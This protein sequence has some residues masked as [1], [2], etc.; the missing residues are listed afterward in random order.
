MLGKVVSLEKARVNVRVD[1]QMKVGQLFEVE[2]D[3]DGARAAYKKV[4]ELKGV[5]DYYVS[6]AWLAIGKTY[7][8]E[9]DYTAAQGA[10]NE[11]TK[12]KKPLKTDRGAAQDYL[13]QIKALQ[14]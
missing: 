10:F 7:F 13:K 2:K 11:I 8:A 3:N 9:K 12:L 6:G 1:A 14:Q 5:S 4:M